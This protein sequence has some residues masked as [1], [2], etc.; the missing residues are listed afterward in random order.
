MNSLRV[1]IKMTRNC[2][3]HKLRRFKC[4]STAILVRQHYD[5]EPE[6]IIK[7]MKQSTQNIVEK[8]PTVNKH[9]FKRGWKISDEPI[10][11]R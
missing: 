4:N 3:S 10:N 8:N 9:R 5:Y 11:S 2:N 7:K 1:N 6:R